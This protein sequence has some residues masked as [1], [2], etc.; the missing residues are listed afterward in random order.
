MVSYLR[1]SLILVKCVLSI[2]CI[3]NDNETTREVYC[4]A[5]QGVQYLSN[6]YL[7]VLKAHDIEISIARRGCPWQRASLEE[8]VCRKIDLNAEGGRSSPQ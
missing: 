3:Y 8:R 6:A 2:P 5:I 7:S 4:T 1:N